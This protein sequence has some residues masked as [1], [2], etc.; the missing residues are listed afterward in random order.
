MSIFNSGE[1]KALRAEVNEMKNSKKAVLARLNASP[2]SFSALGEVS[3]VVRDGFTVS[4][5][6]GGDVA[7]AT[8]DTLGDSLALVPI[9]RADQFKAVVFDLANE[10]V[11]VDIDPE[12]AE[13]VYDTYQ[14]FDKGPKPTGAA[15]AAGFNAHV[16]S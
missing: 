10:T 15:L 6:I 3:D 12:T 16:A 2:E 11:A 4:F 1:V 13:E 14:V 7:R 5:T 9:K 8:V